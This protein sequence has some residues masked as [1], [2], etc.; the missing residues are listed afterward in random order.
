MKASKLYEWLFAEGDHV[1]DCAKH[2]VD[3][4]YNPEPRQRCHDMSGEHAAQDGHCV[5]D[6]CNHHRVE[7]PRQYLPRLKAL[8]DKPGCRC[9]EHHDLRHCQKQISADE[10]GREKFMTADRK[11]MHHVGAARVVQIREYRIGRQDCHHADQN[12]RAGG[13]EPDYISVPDSRSIERA[14]TS[15][16]SCFTKPDI[17]LERQCKEEDNRIDAPYRPEPCYVFAEYGPIKEGCL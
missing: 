16:F 6:E 9:Q 13:F 17:R 1:Y 14:I 11:C 12:R 4:V 10:M 2:E 15:E 7:Q 5:E 3:T 8:H